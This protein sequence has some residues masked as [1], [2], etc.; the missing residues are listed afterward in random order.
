MYA[1]HKG[2]HSESH[3]NIFAFHTHKDNNH[4]NG[5]H[6]ALNCFAIYDVYNSTAYMKYM[7]KGKENE[8]WDMSQ[9]YPKH[10]TD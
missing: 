3:H 1:H 10:M 8:P 6:D 5:G 2:I 4:R 9:I 7:Y